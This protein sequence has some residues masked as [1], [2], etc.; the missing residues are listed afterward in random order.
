MSVVSISKESIDN[1]LAGNGTIGT[2]EG[3]LSSVAFKVNKH[4][5][6]RADSANTSTIKVGRPGNAAGGFVLNAGDETPPIYVDQTDKIGIVGG[7]AGQ[8]FSWVAA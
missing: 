6:I 7:A 2:T 3:K 4:I 8:N 1:F 5:V